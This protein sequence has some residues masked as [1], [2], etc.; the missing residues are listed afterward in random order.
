[1][2]TLIVIPARLNSSRLPRKVLLAETGEPLIQHVVEQTQ[3]ANGREF[4]PAVAIDTSESGYAEFYRLALG[5]PIIRTGQ[6]P[7]GTSRA[8]ETLSIIQKGSNIDWEAVCIVQADCPEISP[9]LIDRVIDELE[10]HPEWDCAT[11]AQVP[12]HKHAEVADDR[13][14]VKVFIPLGWTVADTTAIDFRR[15]F[16]EA[17]PRSNWSIHIGIYCYRRDALLR[18]AAAGPCE[19]EQAESLEQLRALHLGLK[20]GVVLTDEAP[21]GIDTIDDYNAFVARWRARQ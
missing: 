2:K 1:M 16:S 14:K 4:N 12:N 20:M 5:C 13:S 17:Y 6:H 21:A 15:D 9:T 11:A 3:L 8:A 18:Y 7:N 10:R 19:R